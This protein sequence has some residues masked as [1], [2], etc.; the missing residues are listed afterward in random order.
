MAHVTYDEQSGHSLRGFWALIA[1]QF[2]GAFNDNAF[3][4]VIS[5]YLMGLYG[6][7][8]TS[9]GAEANRVTS[10]ATMLFALPFIFFPGWAGALADRYSKRTI[11]VV[12]KVWEVGVM[13]LGLMAFALQLPWLIWVTLFLMT[14]QSTFFSPAKYGILPEILSHERLSWGNGVMAMATFLAII[15]GTAI[16]GPLVGLADGVPYV[17]LSMLVVLSMIGTVTSLGVSRVPAANPTQRIPLNPWGGVGTYFRTFFADRYLFLTMLGIVYFFFAGALVQNN[18]VRLSGVEMTSDGTVDL[19]FAD[20]ALASGTATSLLLAAVA[21][22]IGFGSLASGYLSGGRIEPGLIPLGALGMSVCSL[23]LAVPGYAFEWAAVWLFGI[24]FFAGLYEVPLNALLQA[25]SPSDIRGGMIA[26]NNVPVFAGVFAAGGLY[27]LLGV[28]NLDSYEVF[29]LIAVL[30]LGI[31][32]FICTVVPTFLLRFLLFILGRTLYRVKVMNPAHVPVEGGALL[33]ANHTAFLDALILLVS[34]DRP[35]RF[36]MA[37]EYYDVRW[38]RPFAKLMGAIPISTER[39]PR[40]LVSS[41]R[42]AG[43]AV[44]AGELVCIFAEGQITRT[45]QMLPFKKG[46]ERVMKDVGDAPIIPAYL[47]RAWGSIFSFSEGRFFWKIPNKMPYPITVNFGAPLA[48]DASVSQVRQAVQELGTEAYMARKSETP[49]LH[50]MFLSEMRHHPRRLAVADGRLG[51]FSYFKAAV[52]SLVLAR[53]LRGRIGDHEMV[54]VLLPPSVGGALTN[55]ALP[56]MGR[57]VINLNYTVSPQSLR[58]SAQQAGLTHVITS[59]AFLEKLPLDVPGEPVYLEDLLQSVRS[60]DRARGA[61]EALFLPAKCIE[62]R[63][64][65]PANRSVDDL[66]TIV[67]SSGSEGEP[68]GVMLSHFNIVSNINGSYQVFQVNKNDII[69]GFLPFFHSFGYMATLW[70]PLCKGFSALYHPNPLEPRIIG[71]LVKEYKATFLL[72]TSTLLQG[73]IR[74]CAPEDLSSLNY[75]ICGAEK[76][77]RRVADAFEKKFGVAPLEG[78]GTTECAPVVSVNMYDYRA[79]GFYQK[80][81]KP[82]SIGHPIPGV[83][84]RVLDLETGEPLAENQPGMLY[85]K[86]PNIMQGYL[87]QPEKTAAVLQDGWYETGDVATVDEDGFITITDRLARF[88]KIGGEMVPHNAVEAELHHLLGLTDQALVVAS[89]P[90]PTKGERLVVLHT[91]PNGE[92]ETLFQRMDSSS[93]PKMWL[94]RPSAFYRVEAI[95]VLGTGKMDLKAVKQLAQSLDVGE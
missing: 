28:L 95:P 34:V 73:F 20:W 79:P 76:L 10:V 33:V 75:V 84:V 62:R 49:L 57:V 42:T 26:T 15:F 82:G 93:L 66:A 14:M 54:G 87:N 64:G 40:E 47:D 18:I 55:I 12:T 94:P 74:R 48:A 56:F 23:L 43:D 53:R 24:G 50:R 59:R 46:F 86:G 19:A 52:A 90:D 58:S 1:T 22:G 88:S 25:R 51:R 30:T 2:Q 77:A 27:G 61:F 37:Q 69:V 63:L 39:G 68:K 60:L 4:L 38:I 91:L 83:S 29:L 41:L 67:F 85:I 89:V 80:A 16:A 70:L 17:A 92:L 65:A 6:V 81:Q 35:I 11:T 45:G 36:I 9:D 5:L 78:Y 31:G 32:I 72:G 13:L 21:L 8:E 44:R 71:A 7:S 3:N